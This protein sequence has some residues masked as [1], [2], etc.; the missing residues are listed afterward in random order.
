MKTYTLKNIGFEKI[1]ES[2]KQDHQKEEDNRTKET[3]DNVYRYFIP[4]NMDKI[5]A[6]PYQEKVLGKYKR[7]IKLLKYILNYCY[8]MQY[9]NDHDP[10]ATVSFYAMSALVKWDKTSWTK[11]SKFLIAEGILSC[12][13][14]S[15]FRSKAYSY[16]LGPKMNNITWTLSKEFEVFTTL[17]PMKEIDSTKLNLT[18]DLDLFNDK[19]FK[20][21]EKRNWTIEQSNI[22]QWCMQDNF[23]TSYRTCSTGRIFGIW[24]YSPRE[25]RGC[26]L[27]DGESVVEPDI[28]NA[29]PLFLT[30]LYSEIPVTKASMAECA[31]Y[32]SLV[33]SGAFYEDIMSKTGLTNRESV[34]EMM[35]AFICGGGKNKTGPMEEYLAEEFPMLYTQIA[36]VKKKDSYKA[37]S[38]KLQKIESG[39]IVKQICEEFACLSIHDGVLAKKSDADSIKI[40]LEE[41]IKE[42]L[43]INASIKIENKREELEQL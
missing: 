7:E 42:Q 29:Q 36:M 33:E 18:V 10:V 21:A 8:V 26:F 28:K 34:K 27:I 2:L 23:N 14:T 41:I 12:D 11:L 1:A 17:K 20:V 25:L 24:N 39:I 6:L 5:L 15:I 43:G 22:W 19:F 3:I 32:K 40:R 35:M 38:L 16:W 30:T 9:I 31:K 4:S 37:I 13:F